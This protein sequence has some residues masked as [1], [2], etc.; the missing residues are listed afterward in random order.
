MLCRKL[1]RGSRFRKL[2]LGSPGAIQL[3]DWCT[4]MELRGVFGLVCPHRAQLRPNTAGAVLYGS[5]RASPLLRTS[6]VPQTGRFLSGRLLPSAQRCHRPACRGSHRSAASLAASGS[7]QVYTRTFCER[8][9][10]KTY[11]LANA[12]ALRLRAAGCSA[13]LPVPALF[14][15]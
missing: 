13:D 10:C 8:T 14:R 12:Q 5:L 9:R 1:S 4:V 6:S 7:L 11:L 15:V 2:A 3:V